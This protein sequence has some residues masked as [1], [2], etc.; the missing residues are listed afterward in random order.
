MEESKVSTP[1]SISHGLPDIGDLFSESWQYFKK[2]ILHIFIFN[3]IGGTVIVAL[4]IA[5]VIFLISSGVGVSSLFQNNTVPD[6]AVL[7]PVISLAVIIGII[8]LFLFIFVNVFIQIGTILSIKHSQDK[9][10][11]GEIF[12]KSFKFILPLFVV[13][14]IS[15][16]YSLGGFFIFIIPSL[17]FS[18]FF[19]FTSY[20]YLTS[21]NPTILGSFRRSMALVTTHFWGLLGRVLLWVVI[22][23]A[24]LLTCTIVLKGNSSV[25]FVSSIIQTVVGWFGT[26]YIYVLFVHAD[27]ST[28]SKKMSSLVWPTVVAAIG[29]VLGTLMITGMIMVFSQM[30]KSG[31]LDEFKKEFASDVSTSSKKS[32]SSGPADIFIESGNAKV[33]EALEINRNDTDVTQADEDKV[34]ALIQEGI[35]DFKRAIELDPKNYNAWVSLGYAYYTLSPIQPEM[36]QKSVDAY[37]EA[38]EIDPESPD[39]FIQ[40]GILYYSREQY[41][42][43]LTYFKKATELAQFNSGA[44]YRLGQT[45]QQ[46]GNKTEAKKAFEKAAALLPTGSPDRKMIQEE[47]NSL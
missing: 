28:D 34:I 29:L 27:K 2:S 31:A 15:G 38:I 11:F 42:T 3:I 18:F 20:V 45:Y 43:A 23:L 41:E 7:G 8:F 37:N 13:G 17:L 16:F 33:Q 9:T 21:D 22:A 40:L 5:F 30:S 24:V 39:A 19:I 10:P 1:A 6:L 4:V 47:I 44:W 12:H 14:I 36:A 35:A 46:Q 26:V 32:V 25:S